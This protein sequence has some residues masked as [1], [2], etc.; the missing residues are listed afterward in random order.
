METS[1]PLE[2]FLKNWLTT[3]ILSFDD[4]KSA[5]R[6]D[7]RFKGISDEDL[8]EI[9]ALYKARDD[10]YGNN[11]TRR[12]ESSL[13]PLRQTSLEDLEQNQSDN[14]YS[15]EDMIIGLYNVG[16]LLETRT[17]VINKR[18]KEEIDVLKRFDDATILQSSSAPSNNNILQMLDNYR[19]ILEKLD[20]MST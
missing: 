1:N 10:T 2:N 3:N 15:L 14:S 20:D 18:M 12:V 11:L 8:R 5:I 19:G 16:A 17:N 6:G 4:F 9:Y 7:S 13:E